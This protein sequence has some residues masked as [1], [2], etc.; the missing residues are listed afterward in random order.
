MPTLFADP[1]ALAESTGMCLGR[2]EGSKSSGILSRIKAW[3]PASSRAI[4]SNYAAAASL[5]LLGYAC[6]AI[7][8]Y[9]TEVTRV[10][11]DG[12]I[13][14]ASW[15]ALRV[16]VVA[17]SAVAAAYT[18]QRSPMTIRSNAG[19]SGRGSSRCRSAGRPRRKR[20]PFG[21]SR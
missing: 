1:R 21:P 10:Y 18:T 7:L 3:F 19:A 2:A 9:A 16:V 20:S 13:S 4:A 15:V 8:P 14:P 11:Y 12:L 17:V 5:I 6:Y